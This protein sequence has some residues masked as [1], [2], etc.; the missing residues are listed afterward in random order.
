MDYLETVTIEGNVDIEGYAFRGCDNLRTVYLN[1]DDVNFVVSATG[2]NSC[3]FCNGESNNPNTS[4][5]TFYVENETV[6]QRLRTALG[7]ENPA[8]TPIYVG[9]HASVNNATELTS[10][11][12][13]GKKVILLADDIETDSAISLSEGML[14]NGNGHTLSYNVEDDYELVSMYTGA[15]LNNVTLDNYR[16]RTESATNGVVTMNNVVIK[17][18]NDLTG[19]DISRGAGTIKL[20]NVECKSITDATHLDPETDIQVEYTPYGDVL[21]GTTWGL[22]ATD[23]SFGSLHGWNTTNGSNISLT[24]T[25]ATVFRM[26]YWNNRT[27]YINGVETAWAESG[28]IPVVH[29]SFGCWKVMDSFR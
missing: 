17:M 18:D 11:L 3:W 9:V 29:D 28:A 2:K 12:D 26:H 5:I 14:F 22:E 23:C 1:G 27:L 13:S 15:E 10:A 8:T 24:N 21:V 19:L 6:A 25:T 4:N 16:V 20:N 7:A